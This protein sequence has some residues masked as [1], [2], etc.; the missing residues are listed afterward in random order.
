MEILKYLLSAF[1]KSN[2]DQVGGAW[3]KNDED[4]EKLKK[5]FHP[6]DPSKFPP[7]KTR[8]YFSEFPSKNCEQVIVQKPEEICD[9]RYSYDPSMKIE[10]IRHF[11]VLHRFCFYALSDG[12]RCSEYRAH[13]DTFYCY[14][15][16]KFERDCGA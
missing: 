7:P 8:I 1:G 13:K 2:R 10:A 12:S 4:R 6:P 5:V 15:H 9:I 14:E 3:G 16:L 11:C